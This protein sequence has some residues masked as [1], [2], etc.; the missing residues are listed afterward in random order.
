[1]ALVSPAHLPLALSTATNAAPFTALLADLPRCCF[2]GGRRRAR[3]MASICCAGWR[4][5]RR[6]VKG[7]G[8]RHWT[9]CL[10]RA[11][12]RK[13][14]DGFWTC[15]CSAPAAA[16]TARGYAASKA[17]LLY[18]DP[19]TLCRRVAWNVLWAGAAVVISEWFVHR[20]RLPVDSVAQRAAAT[21]RGAGA[22]LQLFA[23]SLSCAYG[24]R[25][26]FA[27]RGMV[28]RCRIPPSAIL[29]TV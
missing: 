11:C 1:M 2:T 20:Q 28:L 16:V 12:G 15:G 23:L 21:L 24:S 26:V 4:P 14:R 25:Y 6:G 10:R 29:W 5:G 17:R 8:R 9:A 22:A 19:P 13:G 3:G 27:G 18:R 7:F